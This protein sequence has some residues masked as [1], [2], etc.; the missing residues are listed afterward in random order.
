VGI[1]CHKS[2][3]FHSKALTYSYGQEPAI[4]Y[5]NGVDGP[6]AKNERMGLIPDKMSEQGTVVQKNDTVTPFNVEN[7]H[8][9][10]STNAYRNEVSEKLMATFAWTADICL[11]LHELT[12]VIPEP[13]NQSGIVEGIFY[14]NRS[15]VPVFL[16]PQDAVVPQRL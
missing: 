5:V 8:F 15:L 7:L 6:T 13:D 4:H 10:G 11:D 9:C 16:S 12:R 14:Y 2:A 1:G 3:G